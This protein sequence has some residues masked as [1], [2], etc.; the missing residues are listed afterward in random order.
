M[1]IQQNATGRGMPGTRGRARRTR[2]NKARRFASAGSLRGGG[3]SENLLNN[4]PVNQMS[5]QRRYSK[6]KR[7]QFA[8]KFGRRP[9]RGISYPIYDPYMND[10]YSDY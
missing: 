8:G 5:Q 3:V 4:P 9:K 2:P 7:Y 10:D 1:A 6:G